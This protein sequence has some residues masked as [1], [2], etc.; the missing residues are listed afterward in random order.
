[1][2]QMTAAPTRKSMRMSAAL[3]QT[4]G[5]LGRLIA[6][7]LSRQRLRR[8]QAWLQSQPDYML[9]DIGVSRGEIE[10]IIRRGRYR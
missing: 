7:W 4:L 8:D 1:M 2:T 9:R 6:R 10:T 3:P 5:L